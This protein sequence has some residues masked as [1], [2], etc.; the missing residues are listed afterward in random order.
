[1]D[2]ITFNLGHATCMG[3]MRKSFSI[4]VGIPEETIWKT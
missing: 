2:G 4:L 1:M 3:E